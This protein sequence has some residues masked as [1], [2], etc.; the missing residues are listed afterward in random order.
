MLKWFF[1]S[2]LLLVV[3]AFAI[4]AK[5]QDSSSMTGLVT[6]ASGAVIPKTTVILSN[7]NNGSTFTQVTDSKGVYRFNS[8]PAAP[9]YT[10][11]FT[12]DGFSSVKIEKLALEVGTTRTQ[13]IQLTVGASEKVAVSA[14]SDEATLNTTDASIGNNL[15]LRELNEL[16]VQ[17]RTNGISALFYLQP[18][19]DSY[20]GAVAGARIDQTSVTL[21]GLDVNDIAAGTTFA[22][23][24]TAPVDSVEEFKG[25]I[26]GLVSNI[27]TG[28]GAQFQLV[29]KSGTNQFHGNINEYHRDTVTS[30]NTYFNNLNALPR[31]PLIQNQFGGNIGGPIK[32]DKLFFFFDFAD[33]RIIQSSFAE[34]TVPLASYL[35]GNVNYINSNP[36]CTGSSRI[37]TTPNCISTLPNTATTG[38]SITSLDPSGIGFDQDELTFLKSRY[39]AATDLAY[40]DGVNTGGLPFNVPT[41]NI[42]TTYVTRIDYN[43]STNHKLFGRFTINRQNATSSLPQFPTDPV[44]HPFIDRSYAYVVSDVWTIGNNKVNQFY[45]GDVVSKYSFPNAYN[46]TGANQY[47]FTGLSNPYSGNDGQKRRVPIPVVRDD[48]NWQI[49]SHSVSFGG[50]FK[51]IK[52]NSN[53]INDY[54]FVGVGLSGAALSGGLD[55]TVRPSDI[56]S[57]STALNDYDQLFTTAL[58]VIGSINT[59]YNYT[60]TG[61]AVPAGSGGPRAY[62]YYQTEAYAGDN[63][64]ITKNLTLAYGVR[65]QFYTV[66]Y[67]THGS[68]SVEFTDQT[69]QQQSTLDSY[70]KARLQAASS[71]NPVLPIYSV[72][73][74]GKANNGPSLYAPSYKDFAPRF[75]FSYSPFANEKTVVNG[76]VGIV[77]DRTVINAINFLQDQISYL[78]SNTQ[79]NN[80]GGATAAASLSTAN[81]ARVGTN[82]SYPSSLIPPPAPLSVPYTPYD[83][84]GNLYGLGAGETNFVISPN[85]KDPYS[86]AFNAGIQQDLGF[87]TIMRLN[88]VGRLG[89]RLLADADAG[90]VIDV[91]DTTGKSTQTMVQA[92]AQLTTQ[93]RAGVPLTPQPWF[94]NVLAPLGA[95]AGLGNNTNLVAAMVGQLGNRGDI[96]DMLY[97]MAAYTEFY[98]FTNF[99]PQNVGIP[100]QFGSNAYLTNQGSSSYNALL[101]TLNK[102]RSHGLKFDFNYTWQH[103]IDNASLS[104]NNNSLF[105]NSGFICDVLKPRACR[106]T[107]DF[108]VTQEFVSNFEYDLPVG[109][110]KTFASGSS[111][112]LD[113]AIGG[114]SLSGIPQYRTGL[115]V[116]PYSDAYLASFDNQD[117]AIFTGTKGSLKTKVNQSNGVVYAFA[118]GQAGANAALAKFSGPVGLQYGSRNI[119]R[120]AGGAYFDAGLAKNFP[121]LADDKLNLRFRA[122]FFNVLNH[123]VFSTPALNIVTNASQ[124]GQ[125]TN[126]LPSHSGDSVTGRI[127]QFS[128]RLEF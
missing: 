51:F 114:W 84:G 40:G 87:H 98:G 72:K 24:A 19:V 60:N 26:A 61:A 23:V 99:L 78:F 105:S 123:P 76:G 79:T 56:N 120:S 74:G 9:G 128:L 1:R 82:L 50:T 65:Y 33:S 42:D 77:Y 91:P 111:R 113:E 29:T 71:T 11:V 119:I 47:S 28:S 85:L 106:G 108:D 2:A 54:N 14:A 43:L 100:S 107:S 96:S 83:A 34:R 63:W 31:T 73:L 90:Q 49:G 95:S 53:L 118:G 3:F 89:R 57:S 35:A 16:P 66:P 6:D 122:D 93:L 101:L 124:F 13:N 126:T 38:Q 25:T 8:I 62:R 7:S 127:G 46:P 110:G 117:P 88:Y 20:S 115:G 125:I 102:N 37:T 10:A 39:P 36:G 80:F 15:S 104:A 45:Y 121:I 58:G 109:R 27:G 48:F 92:F 18:G 55:P 17:D 5:A 32:K 30:A 86:I 116:T 81:T 41:P 97:T 75:A 21:D 22:V 103:S 68:E 44:S 94:E 52:T 64:K 112:L 67:E 12:H 70:V 69:T 59:N 4:F